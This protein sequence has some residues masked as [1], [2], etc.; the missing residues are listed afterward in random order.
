MGIEDKKL[1][2]D[3]QTALEKYNRIAAMEQKGYVPQTGQNLEE[4][5]QFWLDRIA[6]LHD[7]LQGEGIDDLPPPDENKGMKR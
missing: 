4:Q 7:K 3:Y 6:A 2:H 5:K 1:I